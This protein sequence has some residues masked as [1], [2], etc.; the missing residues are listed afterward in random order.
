MVSD[1]TSLG[2]IYWTIPFKVHTDSSDKQLYGVISHYNK[3][4]SF[5]SKIIS[6][7][8]HKYSTTKKE[9]LKILECLKQLCRIRFG[10]EISIF[11]DHTNLF[12]A[13]TLSES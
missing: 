13:A 10:Y 3:P 8:Q 2:H 7:P 9:L 1:K 4:I 11:L 12:Y 6:N 5:F